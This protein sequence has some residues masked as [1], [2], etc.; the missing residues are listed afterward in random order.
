[1][2]NAENLE[3]RLTALLEATQI[4]GSSLDLDIVL[5]T[6]VQ[7]AAAIS[8]TPTVRLFLLEEDTKLLRCRVGVGIPKE[9][10]RD[11]VLAVGESFSGQVAAT[12]EPLAVADCRGDPRLRYA[13]HVSKWGLIAKVPR[14]LYSRRGLCRQGRYERSRGAC[15]HRRSTAG[16]GR[17]GRGTAQCRG[18]GD[19]SATAFR[20]ANPWA[21]GP[22]AHRGWAR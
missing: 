9:V 2:M 4:V 10:E 18:M 12:G 14:C 1:M 8:A 7:Q 5:E 17:P 11:L 6:I 3:A 15:G 13:E 19:S 21:P 20:A 16:P 22:R